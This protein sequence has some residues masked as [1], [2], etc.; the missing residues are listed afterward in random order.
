MKFI[1]NQKTISKALNIVS[2]AVS[3]KT[4]M[5]VL[6]GILISVDETSVTFTASD[7]DFTIKN[8]VTEGIE[9]I[10]TG[11]TVIPSKLFMDIIR[12]LPNSEI[13]FENPD[14]ISM[15]IKTNTSDFNILT[16]DPDEFPRNVSDNE[17]IKSIV[18]NKNILKDMI[19]KTSFA[20][21]NDESRGNIVGVLVEFENNSIN[22][23]ALDGFRMSVN[24]EPVINESEGKIIINAGIIN[25][26]NKILSENDE[27]DDVV[28]KASS[29]SAEMRI[30]DTVINLR[31]LEGDFIKY[32]DILPKDFRTVT[33]IDRTE[34][35]SA[36]ERASLLSSDGKNNLVRIE[37]KNNLMTVTSRSDAGNVR[38]EMIIEKE[39]EDI[40]IG[41]NSK[42][43]LDSLKVIEDETI[44]FCFNTSVT[45]SLIKPVEGNAFDMLVLP[46]RIF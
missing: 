5:P 17:Y 28:I 22:M 11:E 39:G 18:I 37:I 46:V 9:I 8:T 16:I 45:P 13:V 26:I 42:Y 15:K 27:E 33:Y 2:K 21:S 6:K 25:E 40:E 34:F 41:F 1:C 12:K 32:K 4:T 7:M 24:R 10:E 3:N 43:L 36:V 38:E 44:K 35:I 14:N 31:L 20:A 19:R 30:N 29:N 23:I